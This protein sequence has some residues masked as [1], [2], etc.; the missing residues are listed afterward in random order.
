MGCLSEFS[1][2]SGSTDLD[3]HLIPGLPIIMLP[4]VRV[5]KVSA[6]LNIGKS[7]MGVERVHFTSG[8]LEGFTRELQLILK[9]T[10][11]LPVNGYPF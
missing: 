6:N 8:I 7:A 3:S 11:L 9:C 5:F 1:L 4:L 10:V 2:M